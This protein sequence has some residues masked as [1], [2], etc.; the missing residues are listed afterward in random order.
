V[1]ARDLRDA[2]GRIAIAKGTILQETDAS[3]VS[4]LAWSELHLIEREPDELHERDAGAR[5]AR[6]ASGAGTSAGGM[7]GGHWPIVATR[8]GIL[9]VQA[10]SL[11]AVN[12]VEGLAVY[13]LYD[14]QVVD[15]GETVARAK[16]I[17][18]VIPGATVALAEWIAEKVG[19]LVTVRP[20]AATEIGVIVQE[21]L[22][23]EAMERFRKAISEKVA[24]FGSR[25]AEPRIVAPEADA[26]VT[27]MEGVVAGGAR[28]VLFAG[29]RAMDPMD[30]AFEALARLHAR[31][32]RRGVPAHP[33]SLLWLATLGE[34]P[35]VGMPT[36]GLFSEATVFDLVLPRLLAGERVDGE[37][38][39]GL[40]HGGFL[41]RDMAFRFPPYRPARGRG[42]V[43]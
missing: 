18:F 30:P 27:A 19:G 10:A 3:R 2:D 1:L 17:P 36:C 37:W 39:A 31:V 5:L 14:G 7:S 32:E 28:I 43:T 16:I 6:A 21:S 34:V 11:R 4:S 24:W 15:G 41:T 42:E 26:I 33:G 13:T 29:S 35:V 40:G 8:R 9:Y 25:V 12:E 23:A 22:G 20:F 38:L